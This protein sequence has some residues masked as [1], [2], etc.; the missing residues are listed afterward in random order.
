MTDFRHQFS[1]SYRGSKGEVNTSPSLT[2]PDQ[3]IP[4]R[5]L[6]ANHSRGINTPV[7]HLEGEYFNGDVPDIQDLNELKDLRDELKITEKE[8]LNN[9]KTEQQTAK[10]NKQKADK[11]ALEKARPIPEQKLPPVELPEGS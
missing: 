11:E 10:I 6:L 7:N 5:T 1:A 9:I 3:A 2:V 4:L 8:L